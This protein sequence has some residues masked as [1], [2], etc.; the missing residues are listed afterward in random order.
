MI[1]ERPDTSSPA[2]SGNPSCPASTCLF[3]WCAASDEHAAEV[4]LYETLDLVSEAI[5][6]VLEAGILSEEGEPESAL[7]RGERAAAVGLDRPKTF[8]GERQRNAKCCQR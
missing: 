7:D 2:P 8:P 6:L 3:G 1:A 5:V 4:P